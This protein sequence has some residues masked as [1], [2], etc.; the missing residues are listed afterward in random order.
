MFLGTSQDYTDVYLAAAKGMLAGA[1]ALLPGAVG[2][3]ETILG[4]L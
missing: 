4:L 2:P 3:C 1:P